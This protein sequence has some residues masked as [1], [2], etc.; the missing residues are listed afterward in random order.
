MLLIKNADLYTMEGAGR[1]KGGDV[2]VENGKIAAVGNDISAPGAKIIDAAGRVATPGFVDAHSHLGMWE[3]G[4]GFEGLDGN[5]A[6]NPATPA[7]RALD[8]INPLDPCFAEA[9]QTGGVITAAVGPGSANVIG[10]Q[11]LAMKTY[12]RTM[13]DKV[14]KEPLALKTAFGENP[15]RVY[16]NQKR[17]PSTR[18][19]TAN[20]FREK[21]IA[22]QEYMRKM[23]DP[24]I[25][26]RPARD[27]GMDIMASAL[28]GEIQVKMHAH[29][30]DDILTAVRVAEEFGL[31]ATV[32]HCT[33]GYMILDELKMAKVRGFLLGPL[34]SDRSKIE[35][36]NM[37][38]RAPAEFYK[39][40]VPFALITD[41][42]F[43]PVQFLRV[44]AGICVS[45]G[46]PEYEALKAIT[47][48]P[49][50]ILGL[51]SRVGSIA[52]GKDADI[53]IFDGDPLDCRSRV[54]TTIVN[55]EI[56]FEK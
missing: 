13:R 31:D 42:P 12:G 47:I 17:T 41:H 33:E 27:L 8:G 51:E 44:Q 36:R 16:S 14:I 2:L 48:T 20:V 56:V 38:F 30:A 19:G 9:Y 7:M 34:L 32:D 1:I 49:A 45:E 50:R 21:F 28:K 26:R 15:K 53:V 46:L 54:T 39:A 43:V 55:G 4:M 11:F 52:E 25:S 10:G 24:D 22:A 29:R 5:E 35:L 37:T 18:M 3:D 40:G 6:V 23:A